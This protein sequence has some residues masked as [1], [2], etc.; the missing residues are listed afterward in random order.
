MRGGELK[1]CGHPGESNPTHFIQSE[2][3]YTLVWFQKAVHQVPDPLRKL[4]ISAEIF[5][6]DQ[7]EPRTQLQRAFHQH[8]LAH[9][10]STSFVASCRQDV[11]LHDS[12]R[13]S[14]ES[15]IE[16]PLHREVERVKVNGDDE[17]ST[18]I[19]VAVRWDGGRHHRMVTRRCGC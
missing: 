8:E 19:W 15:W 14:I 16:Q 4:A 11:L 5:A 1:P 12:D 18:V 6:V 3:L 13:Q 17:S 2:F 9:T 10:D 7:D